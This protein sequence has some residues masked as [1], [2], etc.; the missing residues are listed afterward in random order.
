MIRSLEVEQIGDERPPIVSAALSLGVLRATEAT[1][2]LTRTRKKESGTSASDAAETGIVL[3]ATAGEASGLLNIREFVAAPALRLRSGDP[4]RQSRGGGSE[5][6]RAST[7]RI[8]LPREPTQRGWSIRRHRHGVEAD[9]CHWLNPDMARAVSDLRALR[10]PEPAAGSVID[11][12][13]CPWIVH[14]GSKTGAP[15][16]IRSA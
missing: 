4:E 15:G 2:A 3:V 6:A 14:G 16:R 9:G 13:D 5:C 7:L 1:D 11:P 8:E 12:T 10:A